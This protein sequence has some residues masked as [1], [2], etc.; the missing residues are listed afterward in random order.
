MTWRALLVLLAAFA[1]LLFAPLGASAAPTDG[2]V[3]QAV[4]N[5]AGAHLID[6]GITANDPAY[7]ATIAKLKEMIGDTTTAG[8]QSPNPSVSSGNRTWQQ[9]LIGLGSEMPQPFGIGINGKGLT[10]AHQYPD[11]KVCWALA[12]T[13]PATGVSIGCVD[14]PA[15][16]P[17]NCGTVAGGAW[18]CPSEAVNGRNDVD[19]GSID[20]RFDAQG[21]LIIPS[22]SMRNGA[23]MTPSGTSTSGGPPI[24]WVDAGSSWTTTTGLARYHYGDSFQ[25]ALK[26]LVHLQGTK[27]GDKR[28]FWGV[29]GPS[30][31]A[32]QGTCMIMAT[33]AFRDT[34]GQLIG[35][36]QNLEC[37]NQDRYWT[38]DGNGDVHKP[39]PEGGQGGT[40]HYYGYNVTD[41]G[42]HL[43][44]CV[45]YAPNDQIG[46]DGYAIN[47]E[48]SIPFDAGWPNYLPDHLKKCAV[49]PEFIRKLTE[50]LMKKA[51]EK[52]GYNGAPCAP[53]EP[54]QSRPGDAKVEDLGDNPQS[55]SSPD[56]DGGVNNPPPTETPDNPGGGSGS[57]DCWLGWCTDP[58]TGAPD[59]DDPETGIMDPIFEWM[60]DLPSLTFNS[61]AA[62]CPVWNLNLQSYLGNSATYLL[63]SHCDLVEQNSAALG[64]LMLAVWGIMAAMIILRA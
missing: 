61:Q 9:T 42:A 34:N 21:N 14:A 39:C 59:L 4:V 41:Q 27:L 36:S 35:R 29:I 48:T 26:R 5:T 37:A 58:G 8:S 12:A 52:A 16:L 63:N 56:P 33:V 24:F 49:S 2:R 11:G 6:R 54:D 23:S 25:S 47:P 18:W 50:K 64:A 53:V 32:G 7:A 60:P 51:C 20:W 55:G 15:Q 38:T 10:I 13:D 31:V 1:A 45:H 46:L 43:H 17:A 28:R 62:Q 57:N 44:N 40:F 22:Y 3:Q 30:T 19:C